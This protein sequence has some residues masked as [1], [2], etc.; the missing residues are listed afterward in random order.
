[1]DRA[2]RDRRDTRWASAS[3]MA[4]FAFCPRAH[5]YSQHPPEEGPTPESVVARSDG[6][7]FHG[8]T[9]AADQFVERSGAL[10]IALLLLALC[11]IAGVGLWWWW[12]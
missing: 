9:M 2:V 12:T 1:M 8:R 5:Y 11:L 10:G 4:E 6:I 7:R 3:E